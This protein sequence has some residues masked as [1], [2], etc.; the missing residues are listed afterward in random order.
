MT[1]IF[2]AKGCP[3]AH[4]TR[5]PAGLVL[6]AFVCLLS[7][8]ATP[9]SVQRA[10]ARK[11]TPAAQ[12]APGRSSVVDPNRPHV[13]S[14][15]RG[16]C[17]LCDLYGHA[18]R[19]VV[20][21]HAEGMGTGV[22]VTRDGVVATNAHVVGNAR[23]VAVETHGGR[24][25]PGEVVAVDAIHDLALI[26][27]KGR[28]WTPV[29]IDTGDPPNVG[30]AIYVIGHP[31]GLGWSLSRGIVSGHRDRGGIRV[32][33]TD[34]AIS[35]GNS[36]GPMLDEEGDLVGLVSFKILGAGAENLSFARP[37]SVL[38]EFLEKEG[39]KMGCQLSPQPGIG[40]R[41]I[42]SRTQDVK[43]PGESPFSI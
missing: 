24:M 37:S 22:V 4:R 5:A 20:R 17:A 31:M 38:L 27:V 3:F 28:R 29:D 34:A 32:I 33:Q 36:G 8:C 40:K 23:M 43:E 11:S 6:G 2:S 10:P 19:Y 26:R 30:S 21:I 16:S 35:P 25:L 1:V 14:H 18:Q 15:K 41:K 7:A 42:G 13:I 12:A 39:I 9:V